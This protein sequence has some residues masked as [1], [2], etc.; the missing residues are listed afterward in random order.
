M[1]HHLTDKLV[2]TPYQHLPKALRGPSV[3]EEELRQIEHDVA[4]ESDERLHVTSFYVK[5]QDSEIERL[6][7]QVYFLGQDMD[8]TYTMRVVRREAEKGRDHDVR[9][10][11]S[12]W[13]T[14]GEVD[15]RQSP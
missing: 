9:H 7:V 12:D 5:A 11:P 6:D 13:E 4:S 1:H 2:S 8:A 14:R 10:E 15:P 3:Y